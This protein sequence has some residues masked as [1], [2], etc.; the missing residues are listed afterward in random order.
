MTLCE[1]SIFLTKVVYYTI[2]ILSCLF[3]IFS[4]LKFHDANRSYFPKTRSIC[5]R[6]TVRVTIWTF[7][8]LWWNGVLTHYFLRMNSKL[9]FWATDKQAF[10]CPFQRVLMTTSRWWSTIL[11]IFSQNIR[12]LSSTW[13]S[14]HFIEFEFLLW[15]LGLSDNFNMIS[16]ETIAY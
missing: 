3:S 14:S 1:S 9:R 8:P 7:S 13:T 2:L 16:F 10:L 12:S 6:C 4:S 15:Q 11:Q 5:V